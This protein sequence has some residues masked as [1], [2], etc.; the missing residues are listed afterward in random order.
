MNAIHPGYGFLSENAQFADLVTKAGIVFIG[1][2]GK[3]ISAMGNKS[4]SKV[5]L[6]PLG[7]PFI[8]GYFGSNQDFGFKN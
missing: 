5:F 1:P 4:A 6:Q 2:S 7:I 8:P 3:N